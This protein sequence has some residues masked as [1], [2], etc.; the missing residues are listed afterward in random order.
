[1]CFLWSECSSSTHMSVSLP[2]TK[3]DMATLNLQ[4]RQPSAVT[5][6]Q[7]TRRACLQ[8]HT[9]AGRQ[10]ERH[11]ERQ[12]GKQAGRQTDKQRHTG[13]L[14][15]RARQNKQR[16]QTVAANTAGTQNR[17]ARISEW[18]CKESANNLP[19]SSLD[20][21]LSQSF[22]SPFKHC[23]PGTCTRNLKLSSQ[24]GLVVL[25]LT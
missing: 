1:M 8:K 6:W 21:S 23:W 18:P 4:S 10:M 24:T 5:S 7:A 13:R 19:I 17:Q 25:C 22:S 3:S 2:G 12:V 14:A 15:G 20:D 9:S 11:I 16:Q